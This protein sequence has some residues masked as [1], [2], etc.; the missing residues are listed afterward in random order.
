M[1]KM[2]GSVV[3]ALLLGKTQHGTLQGRQAQ[4]RTQ[5]QGAPQEGRPDRR[6]RRSTSRRAAKQC[7]T[8]PSSVFGSAPSLCAVL[9]TV[10]LRRESLPSQ[11]EVSCSGIAPEVY[12]P[13]LGRESL[14]QAF[15]NLSWSLARSGVAPDVKIGLWLTRKSRSS[16][17]VECE[18]RV[19]WRHCWSHRWDPRRCQRWCSRWLWCRPHSCDNCTQNQKCNLGDEHLDPRK[20]SQ[21]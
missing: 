9:G 19:S 17:P 10:P 18:I 7:L 11:T 16:R 8:F 21:V 6:G 14:P 12:G 5:R 2:I 13:S 1:S 4:T 20:G 3:V 15:R